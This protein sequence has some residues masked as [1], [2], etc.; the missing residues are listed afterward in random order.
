MTNT[1]FFMA[2]S[3]GKS[4]MRRCTSVFAGEHLQHD[5]DELAEGRWP[6]RYAVLGHLLHL[7]RLRRPLRVRHHL[8]ANEGEDVS[9][10]GHAAPEGRDMQAGH[11]CP[12]RIS[13]RLPDLQ[14]RLLDGLPPL[15]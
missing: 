13:N 15:V 6:Q 8:A 3:V 14:H 1:E 4:L 9:Q 5:D 10:A 2:F 11:G 7:L 12:H